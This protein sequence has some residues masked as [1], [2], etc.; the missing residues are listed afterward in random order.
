[1][2]DTTEIDTERAELS[3]QV[4]DEFRVF[5]PKVSESQIRY[6]IEKALRFDKIATI[7]ADQGARSGYTQASKA[8]RLKLS[9][10]TQL[11]P[12]R[13]NKI[14]DGPIDELRQVAERD[15]KND[16]EDIAKRLQITA[17]DSINRSSIPNDVKQKI[18]RL[19]SE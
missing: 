8:H 1:M 17:R 2:S 11:T 14:I 9:E 10:L 6:H 5:D 15:S 12:H 3:Y 19:S 18:E 13:V 7:S 4:L 16:I